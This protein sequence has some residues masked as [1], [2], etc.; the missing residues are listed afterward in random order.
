MMRLACLGINA[1]L[2]AAMALSA[3]AGGKGEEF[4]FFALTALLFGIVAAGLH[5]RTRWM[6]AVPAF[7]LFLGSLLF[8]ALIA[9]GG[10][11][12]GPSQSLTMGLLIAS[13]LGVAVLEIVTVV[14]SRRSA[15]LPPIPTGSPG[16]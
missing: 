4:V 13:G 6:V 7:A 5:L 2:A 12:W 8:S 3:A 11:A 14:V 15:P 9:V 16:A 1:L 10:W